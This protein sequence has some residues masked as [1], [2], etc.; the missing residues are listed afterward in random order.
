[1]KSAALRILF[2]TLLLAVSAAA[3]PADFLGMD[4]L[5]AKLRLNPAQK[6]QFDVAK[7]ATQRAV[8]SIGLVAMQMKIR[9]TTELSKDRPDLDAILRDQQQYTELVAPNFREA[10][11]EWSK[12]YAMMDR[13]Q[14][15]MT[16]EYVDKRMQQLEAISGDIVRDIRK[17]LQKLQ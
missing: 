15:A 9:I 16:R 4:D 5:E 6:E 2:T 8:L 10:S 12:L 7:A 3:W 13:E 14:V 17:R 1:M 11:E